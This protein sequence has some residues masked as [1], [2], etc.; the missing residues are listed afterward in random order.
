MIL[1]GHL[2]FQAFGLAKFRLYLAM[3]YF[4][5]L[6]FCGTFLFAS[7]QD[8]IAEKM[9]WYG[10]AKP[11]SNLFVHFDK[12][13]YSNY[14]TVWFT[15]YLLKEAYSPR[16]KHS[17]MA[18]SLIRNADSTI[19]L[20]KKFAMRLGLCFG[21]FE[22]P[23][24]LQTGDYHFLA[25]TNRLINGQPEATFIQ[26]VTLKTSVSPP[27]KASIKLMDQLKAGDKNYNVLVA[28]TTNDNRFL[29]KPI[30]VSFRYG[31]FKK[32]VKTDASGQVLMN[33]P[34]QQT[35][36]NANVYIKLADKKDSTFISMA[37]PILKNK[38]VV[39]FYPEGGQAVEG[40]ATIIG[41]EV[42]DQQKM[43]IATKAFLY[44][45]QQIIDTVE[46]NS[47]GLGR[48]RLRYDK[49]ANYN[50]KLI[51]D[52]V[53][54]SIYQLPKAIKNG[55]TLNITN[56]IV[57]DTVRLQL[58]TTGARRLFIRVHNFRTSFIYTPFIMGANSQTI[59]IPLTDVPKG[60][61]SITVSDSLDRPLAERMIFAHYDRAEKIDLSTNKNI[62]SQREKVNLKIHLPDTAAQGFVSIAVV[63]NNRI[64]LKKM[65]DI[66]SYSNLK[67]VLGNLP[68]H[69]N[70]LPFKD[71]AYI[72]Q[73]L[74]IKG[75]RRYHWNELQQISA[76]DT[77][78]KSDS[79]NFT[80]Q[81][82]KG[83]KL[84]EKPVSV[85]AFGDTKLRLVSTSETGL[86][87]LNTID[88]MKD[89]KKDFYLFI[90]DENKYAF[91]ITVKDQ[92]I[93]M[94]EKLR[95]FQLEEEAVL[96]STL[97]NNAVLV[98]K[99]NEKSIRLK[100]VVIK[101]VKDD[102]FSNMTGP[103]GRNACGDYVC[104]Y[105]NF[106]CPNHPNDA[107]NTQPIV[108]RHYG[109]MR[110]TYVG[111][112]MLQKVDTGF[113]P[114]DAILYGKEFYQNDYKNPQEPAYF[115]TLYWNYGVVVNG[116]KDL[117]L[118]FY[119]SDITG[120]FRAVVQG[121]MNDDITYAE[122]FFEVKKY[123]AISIK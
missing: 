22:I 86:L 56:A 6:L 45:D 24:S 114:Y 82:T 44:K 93:P 47:Y 85:G 31:N 50:L 97:S 84:L 89:E 26:Q 9:D 40:I 99:D 72:E 12:N 64:D 48:F 105:N 70:G 115:S 10:K 73:L 77:T 29:P 118:S 123:D 27:F 81:V 32:L 100:E 122:Y 88:F 58:K 83:K 104:R 25:Y 30:D 11:S 62:Y 113:V 21:S 37:L 92:F 57:A 55:L 103:L 108:G 79:L 80:A 14:E 16:K 43:P 112:V 33:L 4:L 121:F 49:N 5:A 101:S 42:K 67:N 102:S 66:E 3:R 120:K 117:D 2:S 13:I 53:A 18:V 94:S 68:T 111:C 41:F 109:N 54:D 46:T 87:D 69:L 52:G 63:Q 36:S 90:N 91:Q 59:K 119:T 8:P 61:L 110:G 95:K 60:L 78:L 76:I 51:H 28:V 71:K 19:V 20:T 65:N 116:K 74:L 39:N 38:A 17:I 23:D 96:P 75:W 34:V 98:L 1:L 106:N 7:G 107:D 15:G 35:I